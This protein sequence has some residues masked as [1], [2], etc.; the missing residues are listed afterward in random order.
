MSNITS[1]ALLAF[2]AGLGIPIMAALNAGLASRLG[3]PVAAAVVLFVVALLAATVYA[4]AF[5]HASALTRL[6]SPS[7]LYGGGLFV[8]FY[9]LAIT[10]LVPR[11]GVGNAVFFVLLGQ[12]VSTALIDHFALFEAPRVALTARRAAGILLMAAGLYLAVAGAR[13]NVPAP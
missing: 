6:P 12:I 9:V 2:V 13:P 8:A 1:Y 3:S 11:F 7:H 5:G 10:W 4:A